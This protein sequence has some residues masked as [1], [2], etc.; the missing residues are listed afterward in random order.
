MDLEN[1]LQVIKEDDLSSFQELTLTSKQVDVNS[2]QHTLTDS[3]NPE[4]YI[5]DSE[6]DKKVSILHMCCFYGAVNILK[7][8][9]ETLNGDMLLKAGQEKYYPLHYAAAGLQ[10]GLIETYLDELNLED[11]RNVKMIKRFKKTQPSLYLA[12]SSGLAYMCN[13]TNISHDTTVDEYLD[14]VSMLH[15]RG[16]KDLPLVSTGYEIYANLVTVPLNIPNYSKLFKYFWNTY[17]YRTTPIS[18]LLTWCIRYNDMQSFKDLFG[19][20]VKRSVNPLEPYTPDK[21]P[22][23]VALEDESL[24]NISCVLGKVEFV[25]KIIEYSKKLK[26]SIDLPTPYKSAL[27]SAIRSENTEIF[28]LVLSTGV[29]LYPIERATDVTALSTTR[30]NYIYYNSLS[31]VLINSKSTRFVVH[32]IE[33]LTKLHY[34][35]NARFEVGYTYLYVLCTADIDQV[36]TVLKVVS[37]LIKSGADINTEEKI[38]SSIALEVQKGIEGKINEPLLPRLKS[39]LSK[40]NLERTPVPVKHSLIKLP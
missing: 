11:D 19:S 28:D 37:L 34:D 10:K 2:L 15:D 31:S 22:K 35:W 29:N 25:K 4:C 1:I 23:S 8:C 7:Y 12:A 33:T 40:L 13:V 39:L 6:A 24:L 38:G 36:E 14:L 27:F 18:N 20:Y 9:I 16:F 32:V 26:T 5:L 17:A 21:N 30:E 3:Y